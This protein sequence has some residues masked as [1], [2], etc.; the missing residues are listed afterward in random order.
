MFQLLEGARRSERQAVQPYQEGILSPAQQLLVQSL[1]DLASA[2]DNDATNHLKRIGLYAKTLAETATRVPLFKVALEQDFIEKIAEMA[3]LHDIGKVNMS[4]AILKKEEPLNEREKEYIQTHARDGARM[5]DMIRLSF[6]DYGFLDFARDIIMSHHE[7]WDG[8]GYPEGIK[9]RAIPL[10][11]RIT[12][13]ADTFDVVMTNR[14]Y[15]KAVSFETA[16][17][18]IEEGK[19]TAFDPDL[20]EAFKFCHARFKEIADK[21][22][23]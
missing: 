8:T 14:P 20:I 23:D 1:C 12:A 22:R 3:R 10:C 18:I 5:I 13:I 6:P 9:G 19:G 17:S 11:A 4:E 16:V 7:R 21:W 15:A 2:R